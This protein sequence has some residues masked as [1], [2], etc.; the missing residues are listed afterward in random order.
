MI[1]SHHHFWKYSAEEYGWIT[2]DMPAL[3]RDC[4]VPELDHDLDMSGVDQ[5]ISVQAR[6]SDR[7]NRFL[8]DQAKK[9]DDLVAAIVGWAPLTCDSLRVFLDQYIHEPLFKGVREI[10]QGAPDEQFL[11]NADFDHGI[12]E[13]THRDLAFDLLVF[14][15]QLP[16]AIAF[17]DKHPNQRIVL[18]HGGKPP[19]CK[20]GLTDPDS[21]SW[22]RNIREL[23]R[24]P[25]VYCKLSGLTSGIPGTDTSRGTALLQPYA[26]TLLNAF[27]PER[28]MF[29]SDWP[30]C[31]L[32]TTYP[33]WLNTV[34]NLIHTLSPGEQAAIRQ[35]TAVQFYKLQVSNAN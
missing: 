34:D 11:D 27:G 33:A 6:C 22:A 29:G 20:Q 14:H 17:A 30:V 24:R 21:R 19:I 4:L 25:H 32:N 23:A 2:E 1:D 18:D 10:I 28:I 7:E 13:L 15:H 9:S 8:I 5:V 35:D 16:A 3:M 31:L 26:D 12:R